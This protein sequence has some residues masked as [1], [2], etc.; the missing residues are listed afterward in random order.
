MAENLTHWRKCTDPN[1]LGAWDI[2]PG[3]D[4]VLTIKAVDVQ[5]VMSP[6]GKS[7]DKYVMHF[8]EDYK[9]MVLGAKVNY[10]AIEKATGSPYIEKWIGKPIAIYT[11]HGRWFG[12]EQDA[13]RVRPEAPTITKCADCGKNIG[14]FGKMT[15]KQ[16]V[17]LSMNKYGRCLC[18]ECG[19]KAKNETNEK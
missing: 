3:E 10:K 5:K 18:V 4:L 2:V 14:G 1:Y 17:Q 19:K 9:P 12:K 6:E 7:E 8:A 13:L 11:E 16:V 15:A